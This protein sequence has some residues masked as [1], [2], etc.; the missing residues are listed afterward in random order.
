VSCH[1]GLPKNHTFEYPTISDNKMT[2]EGS[3]EVNRQQASE[4]LHSGGQ[5]GKY[6]SS[7]LFVMVT[8]VWLGLFSF[9]L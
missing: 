7:N 6:Q 8:Q 1:S 4:V 3:R 5:S 2:D 9:G